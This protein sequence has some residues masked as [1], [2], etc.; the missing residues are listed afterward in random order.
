M[1]FIP[2]DGYFIDAVDKSGDV[3]LGGLCSIAGAVSPNT[4]MALTQFARVTL[5]RDAFWISGWELPEVHFLY[6]WKCKIHEGDFSYRYINNRL[7]IIEFCAGTDDSEG[8]P[9]DDYPILFDEVSVGLKKIPKEDQA[10]ILELNSPNCDPDLKF[11]NARA[12]KL[13]IPTH[14]FGGE[15]YLVNP[16]AAGK[17]CPVCGREMLEVASIGNDSYSENCGFSGN[18]FVQVLYWACAPCRV[19]SARNFCD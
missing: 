9:Y 12:D 4:G 11:N 16:E 19:I 6:S 8:F 10:I 18:D 13:S 15:P 14:Q 1:K 7:E 17:N 5:T 3:L 2:G